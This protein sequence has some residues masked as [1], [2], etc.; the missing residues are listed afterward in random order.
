MLEYLR[1]YAYKC[2]IPPEH[3]AHMTDWLLLWR[4]RDP[5]MAFSLVLIDFRSPAE[6]GNVLGAKYA[7]ELIKRVGHE[8]DAALRATD[9][10][11]RTHVS[12]FWVLLPHG[13]PDMVLQKLEPILAAARQDGMDATQLRIRK[14]V[15]PGDLADDVSAAELFRQMQ[16]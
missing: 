3:F 15:I 14:M 5:G 9:L 13:A 2:E 1:E 7:M 12:C 8:L 11:C 6:L 16:A 10:L 4:K